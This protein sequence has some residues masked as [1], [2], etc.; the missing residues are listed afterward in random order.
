VGETHSHTAARHPSTALRTRP[1]EGS[2]TRRESPE[3]D[4][5]AETTAISS[6]LTERARFTIEIVRQTKH[7]YLGRIIPLMQRFCLF[8]DNNSALYSHQTSASEQTRVR[9]ISISPASLHASLSGEDKRIAQLC[10]LLIIK[11]LGPFAH[12]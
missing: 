6:A 7:C 2:I 8:R 3:H 1:Y 10:Q 4:A 12:F 5:A 11:C 9:P